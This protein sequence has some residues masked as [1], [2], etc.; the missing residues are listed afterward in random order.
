MPLVPPWSVTSTS[1]GLETES[2]VT[3]GCV[4]TPAC[5][6][7]R[8]KHPLTCAPSGFRTPDPLIKSQDLRYYT[9]RGPASTPIYSQVTALMSTVGLPTVG[10]TKS[11]VGEYTS[12]V[13]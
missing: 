6:V 9:K 12:R 5:T 7:A 1:G 2:S 13:Q 11:T 3:K 4:S 8:G 10:S